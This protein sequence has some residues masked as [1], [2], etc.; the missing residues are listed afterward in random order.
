MVY[1]PVAAPAPAAVAEEEVPVQREVVT[2]IVNGKRHEVDRRS[3]VIG[4]SRECDI[5]LVDP[6][7][8]R[9]HA[10]LR[11]E[12]TAYWLVDLESTNGIAVNG[13]RVAR[14]KLDDGDT[15]TLGATDIVF[16]RSVS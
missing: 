8:S 11:Q 7:V 12:G 6:N 13:R 1:K 9:H 4:R 5:Q 15:I 3:I 2:L 10:E 14:A 16:E